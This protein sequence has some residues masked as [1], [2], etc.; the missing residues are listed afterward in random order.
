[1]A[2]P[3][4]AAICRQC[5]ETFHQQPKRSFLGF[6]RLKCPRCS[7]EVMYP[8]TSGYRITYWIFV[9]LMVLVVA[10]AL[11]QGQVASPGL[12]GIAMMWALYEDS[13]LRRE[14]AKAEG[15]ATTARVG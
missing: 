15:A 3:E 1:M 13:R 7:R 6:Q 14:I 8:L 5:H 11:A 9:G 10:A 4:I 2:L 12:I